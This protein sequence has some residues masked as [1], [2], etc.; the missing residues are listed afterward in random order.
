[1]AT[2]TQIYFPEKVRGGCLTSPVL[3]LVMQIEIHVLTLTKYKGMNRRNFGSNVTL[4]LSNMWLSQ[5]NM[6]CSTS[7]KSNLA[8][9]LSIVTCAL[10]WSLLRNSLDN[11]RLRHWISPPNFHFVGQLAIHF[12]SIYTTHLLQLNG[13]TIHIIDPRWLSCNRFTIIGW[14]PESVS[15]D[16]WDRIDL[17]L[18]MRNHEDHSNQHSTLNHIFR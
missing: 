9:L 6:K 5:T 2:P 3:F 1:M 8:E 14:H 11:I 16:I 15:Y 4:Q 7:M 13:H 17:L 10:P 12:I 18:D